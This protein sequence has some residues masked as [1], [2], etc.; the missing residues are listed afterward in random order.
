MESADVLTPTRRFNMDFQLV[1]LGQTI[2]HIG[3]AFTT[4]VLPLII[5][6]ITGSAINLA[7][8]TGVTYLPYIFFGLIMGAWVDR[9]NRKRLMI[10]TDLIRAFLIGLLAILAFTG[11]LS[12]WFIYVVMFI[13]S[14]LNIAYTSS[15]LA[16]IPNIVERDKLVAGNGRIQASYSAA[17]AFGPL[18]A[19]LLIG[20]IPAQ[21]LLFVDAVSFAFSGILLLFVKT[22]FD[23]AE[24]RPL[25]SIRKDISEGLSYVFGHPVL[26]NTSLMLVFVIFLLSTTQAQLILFAKDHFQVNDS[27]AGLL[28]TASGIGFLVFSLAASTVRKHFS[29]TSMILGTAMC[30]GL[31]VALMG[32][33]PWYWC[34]VLLWGVGEGMSMLFN[35]N[36]MSLRQ[37]IVPGH[38]LGRVMSIAQVLAWS[39]IPISTFIGAL[40]IEWTN[41]VG[42]VY[43]G[44]GVLMVCITI[45]FR[46]T[47][48]GRADLYVDSSSKHTTIKTVE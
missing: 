40:V 20:F 3:S 38:L 26:R 5:F 36:M 18:L 4:F 41:D 10:A 32:L 27:E 48:L 33:V 7:L 34:A 23:S 1:W 2:S 6:Q 44:I 12:V 15:L 17:T 42:L 30:K 13:S 21:R 31:S 47:P 11:S 35:I 28:Y 22:S 19:A 46:F 45:I 9:T 29:L 14:T 37:S 8:A 43:T 16:S 39:I 24:K 25:V